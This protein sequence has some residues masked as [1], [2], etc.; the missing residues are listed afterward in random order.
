LKI[1]LVHKNGFNSRAEYSTAQHSTTMMRNGISNV[2]KRNSKR[3][4]KQEAAPPPA[5]TANSQTATSAA[6]QQQ[7]PKQQQAP[8]S[9]GTNGVRKTKPT[10]EEAT[11]TAKNYR[12]AKE[13]VCYVTLR[14]TV[15]FS[16]L[17]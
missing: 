16:L 17:C 4:N 1:S 8:D 10:A 6:P 13:L 12:L 2:V 11:L 5:P 15:S 9:N 7:A 3:N 14:Y